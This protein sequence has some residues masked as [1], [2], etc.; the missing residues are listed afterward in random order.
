MKLSQ[1]LLPTYSMNISSSYMAHLP[2]IEP[3]HKV[4]SVQGNS[5][6]RG[7]RGR[8]LNSWLGQVDRTCQEGLEMLGQ[9][10]GGA[11]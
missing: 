4:V 6:L 3:A 7:P 2:D 8:P 9:L 10:H 11:E 1:G 5:D